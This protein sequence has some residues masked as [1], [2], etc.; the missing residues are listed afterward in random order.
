[1]LSGF[2]RRDGPSVPP[3]VH[4][5]EHEDDCEGDRRGHPRLLEPEIRGRMQDRSTGLVEDLDEARH[6]PGRVEKPGAEPAERQEPVEVRRPGAERLHLRIVD[7][8]KAVYLKCAVP[9]P[10]QEHDDGERVEVLDGEVDANGEQKD[11]R[12]DETHLEA[13]EEGL[14]AVGAHHPGQ[15]MAEGSEGCD[16][17][18]ESGRSVARS[19][20]RSERQHEKGSRDEQQEVGFGAQNPEVGSLRQRGRFGRHDNAQLYDGA[21]DPRGAS[22]FSLSQRRV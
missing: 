21:A 19:G 20:Q 14:V 6:A 2:E 18:R 10:P 3:V 17:E 12:Y 9:D 13:P 16:E 11:R 5:V 22:D 1:M 4:E 15:V 8:E 7:A